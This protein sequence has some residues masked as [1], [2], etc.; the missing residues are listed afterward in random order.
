VILLIVITT[1]Y[2]CRKWYYYPQNYSDGVSFSVI[3]CHRLPFVVEGRW[4]P[5]TTV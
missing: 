3:C 5:K 1:S 2:Y 4:V